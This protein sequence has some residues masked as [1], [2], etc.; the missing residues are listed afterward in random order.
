MGCKSP[1][2][3]GC[4]RAHPR[5]KLEASASMVRGRSGLKCSKM[6]AEVKACWRARKAASAATDHVNL[7]ALRVREVRRDAREEYLLINFL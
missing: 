5:A 2:G 1:V 3:D 4:D 6:G 7:T